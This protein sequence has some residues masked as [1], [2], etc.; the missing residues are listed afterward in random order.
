MKSDIVRFI[1][2]ACLHYDMQA[3]YIQDKNPVYFI[4]KDGRAIMTFTVDD[5]YQ[6]PRKYRFM[7]F[8]PLINR[9][10]EHNLGEKANK[11]GLFGRY[12]IGKKIC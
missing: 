5:F 7:M 8:K 9:G 10:L 3:L 2:K 4:H 12:K 1:K 11:D 6:L